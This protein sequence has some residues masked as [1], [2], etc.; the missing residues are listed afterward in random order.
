MWCECDGWGG[1]MLGE[2]EGEGSVIG[3]Y[4]IEESIFTKRKR[5]KFK[6]LKRGLI[7]F[8][9]LAVNVMYKSK[10]E[11]FLCEIFFFN[12]RPKF[13]IVTE[14]LDCLEIEVD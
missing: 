14:T 5:I 4:C 13:I 9:T 8:Y 2:V 11:H 3:M 7:N 6:K 10:L 1:G 12:L